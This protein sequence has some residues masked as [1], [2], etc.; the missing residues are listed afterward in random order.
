M[1]RTALIE[2]KKGQR[3]PYAEEDG[4]NLAAKARLIVKTVSSKAVG[5]MRAAAAGL[6]CALRD[7]TSR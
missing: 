2:L 1:S 3:R 6:R 5:A 4:R 7:S